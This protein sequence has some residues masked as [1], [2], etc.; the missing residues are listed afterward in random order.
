MVLASILFFVAVV[1]FLQLNVTPPKQK[2]RAENLPGNSQ[3]PEHNEPESP[4]SKAILPSIELDFSNAI[5]PR[6]SPPDGTLYLFEVQEKDA[7]IQAVLVEHQFGPSEVIDWQKRFPEWPIFGI[8]KC[9]I[10]STTNESVFYAVIPINLKFNEMIPDTPGLPPVEVGG[11]VQAFT[12]G[13]IRMRSGRVMMTQSSTFQVGRIYPQTPHVIY[14]VNRTRYLVE[15]EVPTEGK[16]QDFSRKSADFE[17]KLN[18]KLGR[19]TGLYLPTSK[20]LPVPS[21]QDTPEK[22]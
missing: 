3:A 16:V 13:G 14:F 20:S 21:P 1:G 18:M 5:L 7:D 17:K 19:T 6:V 10:T 11:M 12:G 8:S 15:I 4:I 2:E 9:E 22:K